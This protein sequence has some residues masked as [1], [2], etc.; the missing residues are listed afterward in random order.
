MIPTALSCAHAQ[1]TLGLI[2]ST[3]LSRRFVDADSVLETATGHSV[4]SFVAAHGWLAF[5]QRETAILR[6]TL[7]RY[8]F[9]AVIACG[10]GVVEGPEARALLK[11]A[12]DTC[13]VIYVVRERDEVIS[14]LC[15]ESSRPAWG[16]EIRDVWRRREPWFGE[17]SSHVFVSL[18]AKTERSGEMMARRTT[19]ATTT[20]TTAASS[21]STQAQA[22]LQHPTP[23]GPARVDRPRAP[24]HPLALKPV[25]ESFLRLIRF[26]LSDPAAPTAVL[27]RSPT[28]S[29]PSSPAPMSRVLTTGPARPTVPGP[30]DV[31]NRA[32][33]LSRRTTLLSSTFP[34]LRVVPSSVIEELVEGTDAVELRVDL[35]EC[36]RP[37]STA[38]RLAE[39]QA[40]QANGHVLGPPSIDFDEVAIQVETARLRAPGLP[41]VFTVRTTPQGGAF[42]DD[43][44][45]AAGSMVSAHSEALY[46]RLCDLALSLGV[47]IIG[48]EIGWAPAL[49]TALFARRGRTRVLATNH[50]YSAAMKWDSPIPRK[51]Y[52]RAVSLG[53]DVCGLIG[54]ALR[55]EDNWHLLAFQASVNTAAA[56]DMSKR[57]APLMAVNVRQEGK[58]SRVF[59][60]C[61]SPVSHPVL[62][63]LAAPGQMSARDITHAAAAAGLISPKVYYLASTPSNGSPAIDASL[64]AGLSALGLPHTLS[65]FV[66]STSASPAL[67][68]ELESASFGGM[69]LPS[70]KTA[71]A[72]RSFVA[73]LDPGLVTHAAGL[74]G[75]C[76]MICTIPPPAHS[77]ARPPPLKSPFARGNQN[78]PPRLV[79]DHTLLR[80]LEKLVADNLSPINAPGRLSSAL[81]ITLHAREGQ[82]GMGDQS[83]EAIATDIARRAALCALAHLGFGKCTIVDSCN[84]RAA[85]APGTG[86]GFSPGEQKGEDERVREGSATADQAQ[87]QEQ[88]Q[89]QDW[90]PN[91][92]SLG[93]RSE[94]DALDMPPPHCEFVRLDY[95]HLGEIG[96][97]S[98]SASA[99]TSASASVSASASGL[100][101]S[102]NVNATGPRS[103]H[104]SPPPHSNNARTSTSNRTSKSGF[105][106]PTLAPTSTPM[107]RSARPPSVVVL[108][109]GTEGQQRG[110]LRSLLDS[111]KLENLAAAA[112][113]AVGA[114]VEEGKGREGEKGTTS[115][116]ED[117]LPPSLWDTSTGG[118]VLGVPWLGDSDSYLPADDR[119]PKDPQHQHRPHHHHRHQ[120]DGL[121]PTL[122]KNGWL[123]LPPA[124]IMLERLACGVFEPWT[125]RRAPRGKMRMGWKDAFLEGASIEGETGMGMQFDS[126]AGRAA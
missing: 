23:N 10:G 12:K 79:A 41:L 74:V 29:R 95:S 94:A 85:R 108:I 75:A 88:D 17:C 19:A 111:T 30:P 27:A 117:C 84:H 5:R 77:A 25:E 52:E 36:L 9:D 70:S 80:A 22:G 71:P 4:S 34:D 119:T 110:V 38:V 120:H 21:T 28:S 62:P 42:H 106:T 81:V 126:E 20:S 24:H 86:S 2:A 14:T 39:A 124:M 66:L 58:P 47:E 109:G 90:W 32:T 67:P 18:T 114:G 87:E 83:P 103:G 102:G 54:T 113:A 65:P 16:E 1:T 37:A 82:A 78:V 31:T 59:S 15:N 92:V 48:V 55:P 115:A 97:A 57:L 63:T 26:I 122:C 64:S 125:C 61:L 3:A 33:L 44:D 69:F 96:S 116:Q 121:E 99:S 93:L 73:A 45:H 98:G 7:Q 101:E 6:A 68:R 49:T 56:E 118:V 53:A 100:A 50:D 107:T 40:T 123:Y 76:D 43:R 13:P 104:A 8:P 89:D 72:Q 112:A 46:F 91:A 35:W 60:P 51:L 11:A 105:E